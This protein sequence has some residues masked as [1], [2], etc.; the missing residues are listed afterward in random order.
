MIPGRDATPPKWG[1]VDEVTLQ[2]A[3][4]NVYNLPAPAPP[5]HDLPTADAREPRQQRYPSPSGLVRTRIYGSVDG[6]SD[7]AQETRLSRLTIAL[8]GGE[9]SN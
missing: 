3:Q 1:N 2:T 7:H 4:G 5:K 9:S 8:K 6:L